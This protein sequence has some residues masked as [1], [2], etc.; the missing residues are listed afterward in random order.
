VSARVDKRLISEQEGRDQPIR[1]IFRERTHC[2]AQG[3]ASSR[4]SS[5][6]GTLQQLSLQQHR[7][8]GARPA[9]TVVVFFSDGR[10]R[11]AG[12]QDHPSAERILYVR[13]ARRA[14]PPD[15][16]APLRRRLHDTR[17]CEHATLRQSGSACMQ[18]SLQLKCQKSPP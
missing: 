18:G 1:C 15:P 6:A 16:G 14:P 9:R 4:L 10:I 17:I 3:H 8:G 5:L 13:V 7:A 12:C 11:A 2:H